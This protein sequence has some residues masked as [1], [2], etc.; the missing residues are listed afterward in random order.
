MSSRVTAF[1]EPTHI[2][3]FCGATKANAGLPLKCSFQI[4]AD[5]LGAMVATDAAL[6]CKDT[7]WGAGKGQEANLFYNVR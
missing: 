5:I 2:L 3:V 7:G 4:Y 6:G 1:N